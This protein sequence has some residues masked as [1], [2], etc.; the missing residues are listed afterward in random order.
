MDHDDQRSYSGSRR[1]DRYRR[2]YRSLTGL[3]HSGQ[4]PQSAE[5]VAVTDAAV[6][7]GEKIVVVVVDD[8]ADALE[9]AGLELLAAAVVDRK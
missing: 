2:R 5:I 6:V 7:A 8:V 9:Y 4:P 1:H 3:H